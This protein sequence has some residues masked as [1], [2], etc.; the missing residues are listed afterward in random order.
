LVRLTLLTWPDYI[1]PSTLQAIGDL[2]FEVALEFVPGAAQMIERMRAPAPHPDLLVP[3]DYAVRT[4]AAE[5]RLLPLHHSLLPNLRFLD[6]DFL[7]GRDHDPQ[8][9]FSVPKDWGT[10]G[11]LL[12]AD[13]VSGPARS[14][15]DFWALAESAGHAGR[16]TVLDSPGEVLGAALKLR[17]RSYN[18]SDPAALA[19]ARQDLGRLRQGLH[20]LTT[21]YKGLLASGEVDLALGWN[22]DAVSLARSGVRVEY[23]LPEEGSQLW[24]DDWAI[25][26]DAADP[27]AAHRFL[28][29]LLRPD[30]AA[31]EAAHTGYATPNRAGRARLPAEQRDDPA[32]YP[33]MEIRRRL[34]YGQPHEPEAE[35]RRQELWAWFRA[36]AVADRSALPA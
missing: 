10:T 23:V 35:K 28:D 30:V 2:G 9:R 8:S 1:S 31:E 13:R 25:A 12:R 29:F 4:L 27:V 7:A 17:G 11:Y 26:R 32:I 22:G 24:E 16:V 5:G 34:E 33:P 19:G 18:A 21:D 3:P 36:G 20:S 6:P 14:W 15:A